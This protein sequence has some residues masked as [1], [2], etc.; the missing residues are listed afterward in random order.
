M[1]VMAL[2]CGL[3]VLA[4]MFSATVT[5]REITVQEAIAK[6]QH[7]TAGK[8]LSAQVLRLGKRKLYRIKILTPEGQVRIVQIPA[9]Q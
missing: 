6:V 8:V 9:E 4:A 1:Q 3:A 2:R 7:D 5:A